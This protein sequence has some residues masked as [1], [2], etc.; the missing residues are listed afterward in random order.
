MGTE[1]KKLKKKFLIEA[2][3]KSAIT[4]VF[5]GLLAVGAVLLGLKLAE[6]DINAGFYVLIGFGVALAVG[7]VLF[8]F[9]RPSDTKIAKALDNENGLN[10]KIQTMVAFNGREGDML[11]LQRQDAAEKLAAL[12]KRRL[13]VKKLWQYAVIPVLALALFITA[14]VIPQKAPQQQPEKPFEYSERQKAAVARLIED[15]GNTSLSDT[16]KSSVTAM[17]RTMSENLESIKKEKEMKAAVISAIAF[18]DVILYTSNSFDNVAFAIGGD[19]KTEFLSSAITDGVLFYKA[20]SVTVTTL[21]QVKTMESGLVNSVGEKVDT[22]M[23]VF[24][25]QYDV[26]IADGLETVL[27]EINEVIS[28][29]SSDKVADETDA[30]R[31]SVEKFHTVMSGLAEHL[32]THNDETAQAAVR[33]NISAYKN[34]LVPALVPQSY[35]CIADEFVRRRTAQ[36]F[37]INS[38]ELPRQ[39]SGVQELDDRGDETDNPD[40]TENGGS[41]KGDVVFGS[42]EYVYDPDT[43]ELVP[44]GKYINIYYASMTEQLL[45][46]E[47][48]ENLKEAIKQYFSILYSGTEQPDGENKEE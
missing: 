25:Q 4:G 42:S 3:I 11:E 18:I 33:E 21:E 22:A 13:S 41:G 39:N 28:A 32:A 27:K 48:P 2:I 47:L 35:R 36:I 37:D 26:T 17:L 15:V 5:A 20:S 8:L 19:E 14:V 16:D 9:L 6:T 29:V 30:V 38:G 44:Y 1:F 23:D 45:N 40:G 34:E 10:E 31:V 43:G 24:V 46:G 12:P 7:G